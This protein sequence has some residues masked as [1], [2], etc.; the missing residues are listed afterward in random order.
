ML[1]NNLNEEESMQSKN[2]GRDAT[3]PAENGVMRENSARAEPEV[4][5]GNCPG[6]FPGTEEMSRG[7]V[8]IPSAHAGRLLLAGMQPGLPVRLVKRIDRFAMKIL[9]DT[10]RRYCL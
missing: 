2:Y 8:R 7:L 4:F 5:L 10:T 1:N 9:H 3:C 6:I